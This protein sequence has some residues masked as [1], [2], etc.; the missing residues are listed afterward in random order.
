MNEKKPELPQTEIDARFALAWLLNPQSA[1]L[2]SFSEDVQRLVSALSSKLPTPGLDPDT[3]ALIEAHKREA[4]VIEKA[5][6]IASYEEAKNLA[7]KYRAEW[8]GKGSSWAQVDIDSVWEAAESETQTEVG[9]LSGDMPLGVFYR[10][11]INGVHAE[12]EAGKSWLACLVTV[13]EIR[14]RRH[15]AYI[16]FEDDAASIVRRLKMLG[17]SRDDIAAY[18]HYYN[19]NGPLT[20]ADEREFQR[21]VSIGGSLAIFDGMT[22]AMA[23][24]GLNGKDAEDVAAWHAKLTKPFAAAQ[25]AVAVLDHVPHDGNRAIGSQHKK[26]AITGV[27]YFL[28]PVHPI[29][30]GAI[31]KSRLRVEKDRPA[32]VRA[33]AVQGKT[34]QHFADLV[35]DFQEKPMPIANLWPARP[36]ED[37]GYRP[38]P[39]EKLRTA[40]LGFVADSPGASKSAIRRGVTG[41][42]ADIDWALEW[43]IDHAQVITK[44]VGQ[45]HKH[46]PADPAGTLP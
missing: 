12:S 6:E 39:P 26:S 34:P 11:K 42:N 35:I 25:W 43:L 16:D 30:K 15:V 14:A 10:G 29:G 45:A 23:L 18:F 22:E 41:G 37:K 21:L 38:E 9:S 19:P 8:S 24:E 2:D 36:T 5:K 13:Q 27:S 44:A 17:A 3:H 7:R 1:P 32:W 40:V 20:D 4:A 31:G 46:Y 28:D 33:H